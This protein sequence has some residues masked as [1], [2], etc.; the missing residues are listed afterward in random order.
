MVALTAEEELTPHEE[1][2]LHE[3]HAYPVWFIHENGSLRALRL[4][5]LCVS[6]F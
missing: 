3:N 2:R 4:C 5:V 6:G 1:V